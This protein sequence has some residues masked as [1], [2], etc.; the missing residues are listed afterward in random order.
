[1]WRKRPRSLLDRPQKETPET[2]DAPPRRTTSRYERWALHGALALFLLATG[3][4]RRIDASALSSLGWD[5]VVFAAS[6][7]L[8]A[9]L[10]LGIYR[11]SRPACI[12]AICLT[13]M[14]ILDRIFLI[15]PF[16]LY[17]LVSLTLLSVALIFLGRAT[18]AVF[19]HRAQ[20]RKSRRFHGAWYAA[21]VPA[22]IALAFI[23]WSPGIEQGLQ[24]AGFF[25]D[26]GLYVGI[27]VPSSARLLL[28]EE[29]LLTDD[30][31]IDLWHVDSGWHVT[32]SGLLL[33]DQR[34]V[35]Y[36]MDDD[37]TVL[38]TSYSY[39]ELHRT[40]IEESLG[41]W[42][43]TVYTRTGEEASHWFPTQ[44]EAHAFEY[45]LHT[46]MERYGP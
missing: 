10:G 15:G 39:E 24:V 14:N 34:V 11:M 32:E 17:V 25:P 3:A 26:P 4:L 2:E 29:A 37:G 27:E 13:L 21:G 42:M 16:G 31:H 35:S 19:M 20:E 18:Y 36:F 44:H 33:T 12:A 46:N 9:L 8:Y 22:V 43:L 23:A 45:V 38:R 28:Q 1:M 40:S 30:E 6:P 5:T 7:A 41:Y